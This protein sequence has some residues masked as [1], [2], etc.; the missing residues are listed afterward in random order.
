MSPFLDFIKAF[1]FPYKNRDRINRYQLRKLQKIVR[2]S[3]ENVPF[4]RQKY[5][6][7]DLTMSSP[8]DIQKL[9]V[10]TSEE[11]RKCHIEELTSKK[12]IPEQLMEM[13][14]AGTSG[15]PLKVKI[16]KKENTMRQLNLLRF[17]LGYGWLPWWRVVYLSRKMQHKKH[18]IFQ[19]LIN[20]KKFEVDIHQPIEEQVRQI[21]EIKPQFLNGMSSGVEQIADWL[22]DH[23]E[24]LPSLR[25]L[26]TFGEVK[27]EHHV[28]K[29]NKA[30][31]M[32]GL[33]R[34][35]AWELGI[36]GYSCK[37][38]HELFF[39]ERAFLAEVVDDSCT[40]VKNGEQGKVLLTTLNQ[41]TTPLI[42]YETGDLITL[43]ELQDH[44]KTKY[45]HFKS[46]DGRDFD[47]LPLKDGRKLHAQNLIHGVLNISGLKKIQLLQKKD[48]S[49]LVKYIVDDG[50]SD[51]AVRQEVIEVMHFEELDV[52]FER[53]SEIPNEPSGKYKFMKTE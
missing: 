14:T 24:H 6:G 9:P 23:G 5:N 32:P 13:S 36:M 43:S 41:Y 49:L 8:E 2:H 31:G 40:P 22:I 15:S 53:C 28:E 35:G 12:A 33:Q 1:R 37:H 19:R 30:F 11:L 47:V 26:T 21:K 50:I 3:Y 45:L 44:C 38:C 17:M 4:Y 25:L 42:R 20:Q 51:E 27:R 46:I 10:V 7:I 34:Y 52:N 18:S 16:S 39:N 29:F 48:G